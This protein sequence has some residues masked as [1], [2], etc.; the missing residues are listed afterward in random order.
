[1][2]SNFANVV[3][4]EKDDLPFVNSL[5]TELELC[6]SRWTSEQELEQLDLIPLERC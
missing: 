3:L 4:L 2:P 6:W 5:D 1:M